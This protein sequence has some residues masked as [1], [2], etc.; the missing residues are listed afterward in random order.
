MRKVILRWL[1]VCLAL[2]LTLSSQMV[3]AL[4]PSREEQWAEY[5][6]MF[7]DP[8]EMGICPPGSMLGQNLINGIDITMIG[9]SITNRSSSRLRGE[10]NGIHI[11]AQDSK[12]FGGP[13]NATNPTGLQMLRE[14]DLRPVVVFALGTNNAG[15]TAAQV[16]EAVSL[17]GPSRNVLFVTNYSLANPAQYESNNSLMR[18]A[19][20]NHIN[21]AIADWASAVSSSSSPELYIDTADGYNVHPS[22][23]GEALFAQTISS[24][25]RQFT[26]ASSSVAVSSGS[27]NQSVLLGFLIDNGYTHQSAAA[28]AGNIQ[29]E[30]A[31]AN[32]RTLQRSYP[33][34]HTIAGMVENFQANDS[35]R[36]IS[37]DCATGSKTY[38][39]GF[40]IAQWTSLGR[41]RNLQCFADGRNPWT[42]E[43]HPPMPVTSLE[44]QLKFMLAELT[45]IYNMGPN[46]MNAVASLEEATWV[47]LRGYESP[48]S[49]LFVTATGQCR[50]S[51]CEDNK[52]RCI[53]GNDRYCANNAVEPPGTNGFNELNPGTHS[54]AVDALTRRYNYAQETLGITPSSPHFSTNCVAS[55]SMWSGEGFPHYDQCDPRWGSNLYNRV[56]TGVGQASMCGSGC[57]IASFAMMATALL[58]REVLPTEVA[59]VGQQVGGW[60]V[61][62]GAAYGLA[63]MLAP[64]FGLQSEKINTTSATVVEDI[65]RYLREGWLISSS[66]G[67]CCGSGTAPYSSNGHLVGIRGIT[68]DG[69]WLIADSA[70]G[71]DQNRH[72]EPQE[73]LA[74]GM[75][76]ELLW[77]IRR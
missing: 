68:A 23:E 45:H 54:A 57:G 20:Q 67:P 43:A 38:S 42:N 55:T 37:G 10:I 30:S 72:W 36:A 39:G 51:F 61:A 18:A 17:A 75:N 77:A 62:G 50:S 1:L 31:G 19:A 8:D 56:G 5:D 15:L 21:V 53:A 7:Y 64:R 3:A 71:R 32:P 16:E 49:V 60:P 34:N 65:N 24:A 40:G 26:A 52:A 59:P 11:L 13:E 66:G 58:G 44:V 69:K 2:L 9:D 28:I 63:H 14:L 74:A 70:S 47:V 48:G 4:D 25:L 73:V 27:D 6:I 22:P 29:G 12:Q 46:R 33:E 35:F 76:T 41:V